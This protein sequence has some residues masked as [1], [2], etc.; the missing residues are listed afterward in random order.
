MYF[1]ILCI[2]LSGLIPD[3]V[4]LDLELVRSTTN[5]NH[6]TSKSGLL[7]DPAAEGRV[8]DLDPPPQDKCEHEAEFLRNWIGTSS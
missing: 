4:E 3:M 8:P 1:S 6:R 7:L 5:T 2:G